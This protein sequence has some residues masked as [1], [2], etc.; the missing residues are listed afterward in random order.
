[1]ALGALGLILSDPTLRFSAEIMFDAFREVFQAV[2]I[3]M[4]TI[5]GVAVALPAQS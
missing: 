5:G 3:F 2:I 1:M 4:T